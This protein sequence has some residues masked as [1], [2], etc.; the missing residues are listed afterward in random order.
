MVPP[1]ASPLQTSLIID[2]PFQDVDMF[3]LVWHGNY[4][5]YLEMVRCQLLDEIGFNYQAM[6]AAGYVFPVVDL[7]I[8]YQRPI[9]FRQKINITARIK[10]WR[11]WLKISYIIRDLDSGER[12]TKCSTRQVALTLD[13]RQMLDETPAVLRQ[14]I[15]A[16]MQSGAQIE[17]GQQ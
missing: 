2:I 15:E 11:H 13:S 6:Q 14:K 12:L 10:E 5:R 8:R 3:Q 1:Q 9:V 7:K 16:I 17:D 4:P